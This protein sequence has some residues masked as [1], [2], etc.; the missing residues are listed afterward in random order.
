MT[1]ADFALLLPP[2]LA[3]LIVLAT[4]VPF[5]RQVL[6]R[7]IVFIDLAIAQVAGLGVIVTRLAGYDPAGL[8]GQI[9]AIAFALGGAAL[10]A[11]TDRRWPAVQ[12][13][14]IGVLFVAA[15]SA[16]VVL[17]A[18]NPHAGEMLHELLAGQLL[19]VRPEQLWPAAVASAAILLLMRR[20]PER[21]QARA[22]YPL[23]AVAVTISVQ[24]VGVYLVF[25]SL[26]VPA[27]AARPW[28]PRLRHRVAFAVGAG[29]YALGLAASFL[30]DLPAG[31][32]I[33]LIAIPVAVAAAL[34]AP[35]KPGAAG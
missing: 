31:A 14:L 22:F 4:H 1:T 32:A 25:A 9:G 19:W 18:G 34:A 33:V 29:A 8:A 24:L 2:M 26:I 5:G 35:A 13:A 6:D 16:G 21:T 23:F 10:L 3:G 15:A 20:M 12:E 7:G 11:A 28:P 27:L 30:A 17:L